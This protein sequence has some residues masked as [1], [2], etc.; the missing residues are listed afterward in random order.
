MTDHATAAIEIRGLTKTFGSTT[1][2]DGLDLAVRPGSVHGFLG[3]NGAGK[4]TTIRALLGLIRPDAGEIRVLGHD[5]VADPAAATRRV[6][7]VPGDVALWPRLTGAETL[8]T[9]ARLRG[10][11]DRGGDDPA[12]RAELVE[13]FDLDPAKKV[14]EYSKGNRQKVALIAAFAADVDA[15]VLDEPTSGLDPLMERVF[16]DCVAEATARGVAVLLSSHI[17]SEVQALADEVTIIRAGAVVQSGPLAELTA[18]RGARVTATLPD[19][20]GVDELVDH[21]AVPARLRELLDAG[22]TDLGCTPPALADVFLAHYSGAD[23]GGAR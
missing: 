20:A 5:P 3:P 10:G 21:A 15:L 2:V 18:L 6:A 19:G 11:G 9:L 17:L 4:S 13:R 7:Y 8:A 23:E 12:R 14:R 22:A 16:A 1:A